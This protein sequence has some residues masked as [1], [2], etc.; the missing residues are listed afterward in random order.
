MIV[1][2]LRRQNNYQQANLKT[3]FWDLGKENKSN[4]SL[5]PQPPCDFFGLISLRAGVNLDF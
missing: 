4:F 5:I 1:W 2:F 3:W